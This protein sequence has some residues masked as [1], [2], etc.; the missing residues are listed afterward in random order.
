MT[1]LYYAFDEDGNYYEVHQDSCYPPSTIE[2]KRVMVCYLGKF[3]YVHLVK[4]FKT[5]KGLEN[6]KKRNKIKW[7]NYFT[8]LQ[9][10]LPTLEL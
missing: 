9:K 4:W 1:K 8:D 10:H 3:S 2:G 6:Y 7:L 5:K